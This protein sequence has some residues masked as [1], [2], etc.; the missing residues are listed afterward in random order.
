MV[1]S[2]YVGK[3]LTSW[4]LSPLICRRRITMPFCFLH[5]RTV[6]IKHDCVKPLCKQKVSIL[7]TTDCCC[8]C[9]DCYC[10][11][12]IIKQVIPQIDPIR[13]DGIRPQEQFPAHWLHGL[14]A[15]PSP[16]A[17][18]GHHSPPLSSVLCAL[19]SALSQ[20]NASRRLIES[21]QRYPIHGQGKL[22]QIQRTRSKDIPPR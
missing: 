15:L 8:F 2:G 6:R 17:A 4:N 14:P 12:F 9:Y 3:L 13:L 7:T 18:P 11:S 19:S 10:F 1:D 5:R 22:Q 16:V 21:G 20:G